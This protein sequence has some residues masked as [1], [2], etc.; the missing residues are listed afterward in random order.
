MK[1]NPHSLFKISKIL[2]D[3]LIVVNVFVLLRGVMTLSRFKFFNFSIKYWLKIP[4][5]VWE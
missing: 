1:I 4:K 5:V 3:G 2:T